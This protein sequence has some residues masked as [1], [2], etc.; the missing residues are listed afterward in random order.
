MIEVKYLL[1]KGADVNK[2]YIYGD[3]IYNDA[4]E[5]EEMKYMNI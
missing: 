4:L 5:S 2:K 1:S 3:D